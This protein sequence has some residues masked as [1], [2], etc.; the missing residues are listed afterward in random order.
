MVTSADGD[1]ATPEA[2]SI[3]PASVIAMSPREAGYDVGRAFAVNQRCFNWQC[4]RY[5]LA[6]EDRRYP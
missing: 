1:A 6:R 3:E 4:S 5:R 2:E